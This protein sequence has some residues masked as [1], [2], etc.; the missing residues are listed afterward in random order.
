VETLFEELKRYVGFGPADEAA[1]RALHPLASPR[2][3]Q[4][5]EVF[6]QR[7]L[8]H[9][10]ARKA[11]ENESQVGR[12]KVTLVAWMGELLQGPWDEAY[13]QK[14]CRIGR[15]HVRIALPQHYMFGAM[16]LLRREI[17]HIVDEHFLSR[18][19]QLRAARSAVGRILD[20]ELAIMLHTYR[21]DYLAQ[22]ARAERL[23]TF[24]QLVGSIGHELR[25]PLGVIETSLF[26]LKGR[27]QGDE[28]GE[29]HVARIGEQI[30]IANKIV[31]DLLD[32]IRDKPL[33]LQRVQ[34]ARSVEA[35]V[36]S[37]TVPPGVAVELQGLAGLPEVEGDEGQLRQVFLNL[38]ENAIHAVGEKGRVRIDGEVA[39]ERV[40]VTVEDS[41]PGLDPVVRRRLFEPLITTKAKGVGL[42]L[43][44]VKRIV[45]RHGGTIAH[46]PRD[47][48]GARFVLSF[49]PV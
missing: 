7:I 19:E 16:N 5:S 18:P 33:N 25:N 45:E 8:E 44:L 29:K 20:L 17:N 10:G 49:K 46:A 47:G 14:R 3:Q 43:P 34:L 13:F 4:V 6:Y 1:L 30:V 22:G 40:T 26:I 42:G 28:R 48:T 37:L 32:M 23:A 15:V 31:S 11:L 27:L 12:L 35:A 9:E 21:E 2:F 24:G 41:G 39:R 38:I 36:A